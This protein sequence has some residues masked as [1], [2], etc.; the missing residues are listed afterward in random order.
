VAPDAIV[1]AVRDLVG[2]PEIPT[3]TPATALATT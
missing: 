3:A 2:T 1:R